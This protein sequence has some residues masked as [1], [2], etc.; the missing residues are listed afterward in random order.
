VTT[1]SLIAAAQG[2]ASLYVISGMGA[3]SFA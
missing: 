3:I 2:F 1:A